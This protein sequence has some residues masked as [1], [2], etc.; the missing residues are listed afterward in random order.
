[1]DGFWPPLTPPQRAG[2]TP[3]AMEM[4]EPYPQS[5]HQAL[6]DANAKIVFDK[7]HVVKHLHDAV[8][9]V[10]RAESPSAAPGWGTTGS[11]ARSISGSCGVAT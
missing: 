10:R 9:P 7:F 8:D 2:I 5:T 6:P 11:P 3:V 4:W 1:L